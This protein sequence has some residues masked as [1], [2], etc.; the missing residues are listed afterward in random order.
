MLDVV[1]RVPGVRPVAGVITSVRYMVDGDSMQPGLASNQHILVDR[2][3]YRFRPPASGDMVVLRDPGQPGVHCIKR[4]I[5][6]PGEHVRM[7]LGRAFID[8]R[9]LEE[10]YSVGEELS[11]TPLPSQ[12]LLDSGEYFVLGDHRQDSRDSRSFGP[13]QRGDI[14]GKAW[15]RYWPPGTWKRL[16]NP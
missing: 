8:G 10:P 6:L 1:L 7:E 3:A 2:L 15:F 11:V 5:G 12:W 16:R 4:I 9:A 14:I 13:V